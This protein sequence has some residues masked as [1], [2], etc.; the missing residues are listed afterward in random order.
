MKKKV[1]MSRHEL[2]C[3]VVAG[4]TGQGA[5]RYSFANDGNTRWGA[6]FCKVNL[7]GFN[8]ANVMVSSKVFAYVCA[9]EHSKLPDTL[10]VEFRHCRIFSKHPRGDCLTDTD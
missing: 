6:R 7:V 5:M 10:H 3:F 1:S 8:P 2:S 9:S 4:V